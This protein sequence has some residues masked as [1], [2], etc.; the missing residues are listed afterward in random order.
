MIEFY[1]DRMSFCFA[2]GKLSTTQ[3]DYDTQDNV[4]LCRAC[5]NSP[6]RKAA[7]EAEH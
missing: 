6:G 3:T 2:C 1:G 7:I 5:W 4:N